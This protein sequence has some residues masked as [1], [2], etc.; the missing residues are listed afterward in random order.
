MQKLLAVSVIR[1][2]LDKVI[3]GS[4]KRSDSFRSCLHENFHE[5]QGRKWNCPHSQ[6][7]KIQLIFRHENWCK[8]FRLRRAVGLRDVEES[9]S[10]LVASK[11]PKLRLTFSRARK[12]TGLC[13]LD[14]IQ[15][16]VHRRGVH[17]GPHAR[18]PL[19]YGPPPESYQAYMGQTNLSVVIDCSVR[20]HW[21]DEWNESAE[22]SFRKFRHH[23]R[24]DGRQLSGSIAT[25]ILSET[26]RF[27]C[28][29]LSAG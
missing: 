23:R 25:V 2:E 3:F 24:L 18:G 10:L 21:G 20:L 15:V 29:M 1:N 4:T 9:K 7:I 28:R 13:M 6:K 12:P 5:G 14:R 16:G 17:C 8:N 26:Y 27:F 22:P 19:S 11:S